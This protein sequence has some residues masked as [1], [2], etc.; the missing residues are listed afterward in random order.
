[1]SDDH[2]THSRQSKDIQGFHV[3]CHG[4]DFSKTYTKG[5]NDDAYNAASSAMGGHRASNGHEKIS[6]TPVGP[7]EQEVTLDLPTRTALA[8]VLEDVLVDD[9][10]EQSHERAAV[11]R[12]LSR[13]ESHETDLGELSEYVERHT[14]FGGLKGQ[15][16]QEQ[17]FEWYH[18]E[19]VGYENEK[20]PLNVRERIIQETLDNEP[21]TDLPE[22][23]F[24]VGEGVHERQ[25]PHYG[26]GRDQ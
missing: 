16:E 2:A 25:Q 23:P 5:D 14:E 15:I 13:I 18:E 3:E 17:L 19:F 9:F 20:R 12:L 10:L 1:M 6:I 21:S 4:C 22:F 7:L 26:G 11:A 24:A 8:N